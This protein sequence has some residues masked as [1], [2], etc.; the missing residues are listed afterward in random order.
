MD[1]GKLD[2]LLYVEVK[3]SINHHKF[4]LSIDSLDFVGTVGNINQ[5]LNMYPPS[6]NPT[7]LLLD[8]NRYHTL[9]VSGLLEE[10]SG[11]VHQLI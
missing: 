2:I 11:W 6:P 8:T 9:L 4:P 10:F 7:N 1:R 5:Y 3:K